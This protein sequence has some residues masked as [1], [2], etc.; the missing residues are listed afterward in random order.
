MFVSSKSLHQIFRFLENCAYLE[1]VT[2]IGDNISDEWFT[3]A[4][5]F[6]ITK[7]FPVAAQITDSDGQFMLIEAAE[8]LP[9][10]TTPDN[11]S[12]RLF[13]VDGELRFISSDFLGKT[14]KKKLGIG[15][16]LKIVFETP[17]DLISVTSEFFEPIQR[18][19]NSFDDVLRKEIKNSQTH[20]FS[21]KAP[22]KVL[23]L[24]KILPSLVSVAAKAYCFRNPIDNNELRKMAHFRPENFAF[25]KIRTSRFVYAQLRSAKHF[26]SRQFLDASFYENR[27]MSLSEEIGAKITFGLEILMSEGNR[28]LKKDGDINFDDCSQIV[29]NFECEFED[30]RKHL[31]QIKNQKCSAKIAK[32]I[33]VLKILAENAKFGRKHYKHLKFSSQLIY[34]KLLQKV[35]KHFPP[36][37][38]PKNL[39]ELQPNDSDEWMEVD[40]NDLNLFFMES[41][42]F[43]NEK[44]SRFELKKIRLAT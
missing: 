33:F 13:V 21:V 32:K 4:A 5:V 39:N 42:S 3:T 2:S 7:L 41:A 1:S 23:R 16:A 30:F 37:T 9:E 35:L 20:N 29:S 28:H 22:E 12:N 44:V 17:K 31:E 40:P 26:H 38:F 8:S 27:E 14:S 18:R 19:I 11:S 15:E 10:E 6:E 34:S 25:H 43:E 24:L 36:Q